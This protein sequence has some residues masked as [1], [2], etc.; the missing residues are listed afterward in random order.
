MRSFSGLGCVA[1]GFDLAR[2]PCMKEVRR[3]IH[4]RRET[5]AIKMRC[6]ATLL[7]A[8]NDKDIFFKHQL[9]LLGVCRA[10]SGIAVRRGVIK[11]NVLEKKISILS[12]EVVSG[13]SIW[14]N[15]NESSCCTKVVVKTNAKRIYENFDHR[16]FGNHQVLF[17]G[18]HRKKIK[19]LATLIG[20]EVIEEDI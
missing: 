8:L 1:V 2:D 12:G 7:H 4:H 19:D 9:P 15:F 11:V 18:D 6:V 13:E 17:Y 10:Q 14:K 16:T 20:F 3:M 5:T